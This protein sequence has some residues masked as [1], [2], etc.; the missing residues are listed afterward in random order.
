LKDLIGFRNILVH[1]YVELDKNLEKNI[2]NE[3]FYI[4]NNF[5]KEISK[6]LSNLKDQSSSI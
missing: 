5:V 4:I 1:E 3:S 2:Y 6:F